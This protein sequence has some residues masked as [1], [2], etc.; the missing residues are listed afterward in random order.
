MSSLNIPF[1]PNEI[2]WEIFTYLPAHD[3]KN[4]RMTCHRF[5]EL[6]DDGQLVETEEIVFHGD[7]NTIAALDLLSS[8][9]RRIHNI[10]FNCVVRITEDFFPFFDKHGADI[11]S[12]I[13]WNCGF[14][15]GSFNGIMERC[16]GLRRI[17]LALIA[18]TEDRREMQ[19]VTDAI[20]ALSN[21][22]VTFPQITDVKLRLNGKKLR[23]S[24]KIFLQFFTLFPNVRGVDLDLQ[25]EDDPELSINLSTASDK[26]SDSQLTIFCPYNQIVKLRNQLERLRLHFYLR[27]WSCQLKTESFPF[28][29]IREFAQIEMKNLREL[30]LNFSVSLDLISPNSFLVYQNVTH[31]QL[32]CKRIRY[33]PVESSTAIRTVL[34]TITRLQSLILELWDFLMS[35]QCFEELIRSQL[36]NLEIIVDKAIADFQKS[37]LDDA[38]R[39]N[40]LLKHLTIGKAGKN[41]NPII[42]LFANYCRSLERLVFFEVREYHLLNIFKYQ[43][44]LRSLKLYNCPHRF[45]SN[46]V[47]IKYDEY[48]QYLQNELSQYRILPYLTHLQI[49]EDESDLI[50]FFLGEFSFPQLKTLA[51]SIQNVNDQFWQVLMT[52]KQIECLQLYIGSSII[53]FPRLWNLTESLLNLRHFSFWDDY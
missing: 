33:P 19:N 14:Q 26:I 30:S 47:S 18:L 13:F 51:I 31:L 22:S 40:Y 9:P 20:L 46:S 50:N 35:K 29:T 6:C 49:I 42:S 25:L 53:F 48:Q 2:W 17:V 15:Q 16:T 38:L 28:Q 1:L 36:T 34:A 11:R 4:I 21:N 43:K 37:S 32:D 8:S 23:W 45:S 7:L 3:R 5:N 12:L 44:N 24:D 52:M 10:R 41:Y 39:P 27:R